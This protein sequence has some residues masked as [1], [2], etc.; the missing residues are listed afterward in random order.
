MVRIKVVGLLVMVLFSCNSNKDN[1]KS[2][3]DEE[4]KSLSNNPNVD[5]CSPISQSVLPIYNL[6]YNLRLMDDANETL[7]FKNDSIKFYAL[8][9]E[10]GN[11]YMDLPRC[12]IGKFMQD[13]FVVI[14]KRE[15][16]ELPYIGDTSYLNSIYYSNNCAGGFD[17]SYSYLLKDTFNVICSRKSDL[18]KDGSYE[19]II[20]Y[21]QE[22]PIETGG[23]DF[24]SSATG[25]ISIY[26]CED[27]KWKES[28]T[29]DLSKMD[30]GRL[31]SF[32]ILSNKENNYPIF[33][34][35]WVQQD[36]HY[37]YSIYNFI[38]VNPRTNNP[39]T[40]IV[41]LKKIIP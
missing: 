12:I 9:Y 25:Y 7:I 30:I 16:N 6:S 8:N 14:N 36:R 20:Y 34:M 1:I 15:I 27:N 3:K 22:I 23:Y 31:A 39:E 24:G 11:L 26:K 19:L 18:N 41:D 37:Y 29:I 33:Y 40:T 35:R 2:S 10:N 28:Q 4:H 5:F 17:S 21:S 38:C 13:S 32:E